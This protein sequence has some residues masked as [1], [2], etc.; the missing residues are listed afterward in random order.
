MSRAWLF[1]RVLLAGALLWLVFSRV[2]PGAALEVLRAAPWWAFGL[3]MVLLIGNTLLHGFRL[4]LLAPEPRPGP[5]PF[6]RVA[7]I[8]N[9]AGLFLP[10]GGGEA[11]KVVALAREVG[12]YD[13]AVTVLGV[14]RLMELVPWGLLLAWGGVAVL[15]GR[16]PEMVPLAFVCAFGMMGTVAVGGMVLRQGD[17]ASTW[18]PSR[19][20]PRLR[21]LVLLETPS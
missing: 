17:A 8:G 6:F 10:S 21:K 16:L 20:R 1:C 15:P 14:V 11:A 5:S 12:G 2:D 13:R 7:L 3:P 9:F 4:Y 18:V 19:F